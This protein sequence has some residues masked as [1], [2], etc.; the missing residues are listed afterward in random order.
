MGKLTVQTHLY[1]VYNFACFPSFLLENA[2]L[3]FGRWCKGEG[4][5]GA[6]GLLSAS[7]SPVHPFSFSFLLYQKGHN[8]FRITRGNL[9][10]QKI[11]LNY[12]LVFFHCN[13]KLGFYVLQ[14]KKTSNH[15]FE[16]VCSNMHFSVFM[17]V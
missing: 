7:S 11:N 3:Q 2:T 17:M 5:E 9:S 15:S 1:R 12:D 10:Q 14:L 6:V 8:Y 4:K 16:P 13:R